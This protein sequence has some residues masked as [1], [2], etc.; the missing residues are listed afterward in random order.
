VKTFDDAD[1]NGTDVTGLRALVDGVDAVIYETDLSGWVRFV[2]R[3]AEELFG[4]P[5]E[6]WRS[7][8]GFPQAITYHEDRP[9]VRAQLYQCARHADHRQLEY[10]I[11]AADGQLVWVRELVSPSRG[12]GRAVRSL[13]S[14]LWKID[15]PRKAVRDLYAAHLQLTEQLDEMTELRELSQ[16]L[17]VTLELPPLLE[18]IL[19]A[20]AAIQ[21]AEIGMVRLYDPARRDLRIV[22]S[23]GLPKEFLER[24]GR[25]SVDDVACG[26]AIQQGAPVIIEDVEA[27]TAAA[28]FFEPARIGG[29]RA[30]YSTL[31]TGRTGEL[32]GTIAT[33][34]REPHR[35][36]DRE[37]RLVELFARQAADFVENARLKEALRESDRRKDEALAALAHEIRNPLNVILATSHVLRAEAADGSRSVELCELITREARLLARLVGELIEASRVGIGQ[38][39]L[40]P[41]SVDVG[42]AMAKAT[43]SVFPIVEDRR[44]EL[45]VVPPPGPITVEADPFRLEQILVNLLVNASQYTDPGGRI[46][47]DAWEEAEQAAIRVRDTGAGISADLLPRIFEPFVRGDGE[48]RHAQSGLGLGLALVKTFAERQG[49]NV[50]A[51][52]EGPGRGSEFVVRLPKAR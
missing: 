12:A 21:G 43:Q 8:P 47:L 48:S 16:R 42:S 50:T 38:T 1:P 34:F 15:P 27:D 22:A 14:V 32:L 4:Y 36:S 29:Y 35:P 41:E 46:I 6:R 30:K 39:P 25:V 10:R 13:R 37:V 31:L 33:C 28:A 24:Y 2:N 49:G 19:A 52:S 3:R 5:A 17:L 51:T 44:H 7:Q 11:V 45:A 9:E 18:E 40:Q 20:T 26:L 23:M